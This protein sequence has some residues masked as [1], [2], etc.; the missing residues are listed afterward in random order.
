MWAGICGF[1]VWVVLVGEPHAELIRGL[2]PAA[3]PWNIVLTNRLPALME[4]VCWLKF[5]YLLS[6]RQ[7]CILGMYERIQC[8]N[9]EPDHFSHQSGRHQWMPKPSEK[10]CWG[11]ESWQCSNVVQITRRRKKKSQPLIMDWSVTTV[12]THSNLASVTTS[13][14]LTNEMRWRLEQHQGKNMFTTT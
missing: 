8:F 2:C 12:I 1:P 14:V 4:T 7:V 6:Q 13:H 9:I 11:T 3:L 10:G 5:T